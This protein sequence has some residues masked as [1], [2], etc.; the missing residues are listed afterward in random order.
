V[1]VDTYHSWDS[2]TDGGFFPVI[3]GSDTNFSP[4]CLN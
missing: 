3:D 1:V 4:P 2:F